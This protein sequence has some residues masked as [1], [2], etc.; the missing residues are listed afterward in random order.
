MR[1][2]LLLFA[3]ATFAQTPRYTAKAEMQ[4]PEG[5]RD[6]YFAGSNLGVSY[7]PQPG[8]ENFFKNIYIQKT[9]AEAF[10]KTGVFPQG[11]MLVMEIY[12]PAGDAA[13]ARRG[14]FQGAFVGI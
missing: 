14:Q 1:Y 5:Y 6:W 10:R 12:K 7:S 11:T 9:A 13:P 4:F 2:A 8:T 3:A